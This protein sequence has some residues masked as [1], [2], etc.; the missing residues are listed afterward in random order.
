MLFS[1]QIP[2]H[3]SAVGL[4]LMSFKHHIFDKVP[5][6]KGKYKKLVN[7]LLPL[8]LFYFTGLLLNGGRGDWGTEE[9]A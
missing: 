6:S 8:L 3:I 4:H 2:V 9:K 1:T 5:Q 7:V